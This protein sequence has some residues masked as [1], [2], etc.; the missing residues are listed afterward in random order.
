MSGNAH[1]A[2]G[3]AA[4]AALSFQLAKMD[5]QQAASATLEAIASVD[6][7][8]ALVSMNAPDD[9]LSALDD[10]VRLAPDD[11]E[12]WLL[13]ATLLRRL[14]RLDEAQIAIER[15][16]ELAPMDVQVGL[17]AGVIAVLSGRDGAA[18]ESWLS[19]VEIQPGSLAAQIAQDY[20]TQL[21]E[22]APL[23]EETS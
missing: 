8:R 3:D 19:V 16:G 22:P 11:P 18:R 2:G 13:K 5:A 12:G 4:S 21:G 6:L 9:A 1:L 14:E 23:P 7:A 20:L 17:E 10:A 15:A